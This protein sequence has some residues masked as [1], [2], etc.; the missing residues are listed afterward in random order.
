MTLRE[1]ARAL[2]FH[3]ETLRRLCRQ[4]A[5]RHRR[6]G[7]RGG[8]YEFEPAWLDDYRESCEVAPR[9]QGAPPAAFTPGRAAA[10]PEPL[11]NIRL[12]GPPPP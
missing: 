1:A 5:V 3:E 2:G 12:P 7:P 8:R 10:A 11:R 6:V 9:P 4:G